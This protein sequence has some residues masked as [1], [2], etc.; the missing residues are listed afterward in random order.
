M[1]LLRHPVTFLALSL[2]GLLL[3]LVTAS[4]PLYLA[5]ASS[6]AVGN[7]I[8]RAGPAVAGLT[9]RSSGPLS[10][11][12]IRY[13]TA[14]LDTAV[15]RIDGLRPAVS[16]AAASEALSLENVVAAR[17]I[18]HPVAVAATRTD[19]VRNLTILSRAPGRGWWMARSI[20]A[21]AQVR[22][23]DQ[24]Q[25]SMLRDDGSPLPLG[26]V[27]VVGI[28]RDLSGLP[29]SSYWY[30]IHRFILPTRLGDPLPPPLLLADQQTFSRLVSN[31]AADGFV[32]WEYW[33]EQP[34]YPPEK[35][36]LM[37][38]GIRRFGAQLADPSSAIGIGFGSSYS[39]FPDI[40]AAGTKTAQV[41]SGPIRSLVVA[42]QVVVLLLLVAAGLYAV[43]RRRAEFA[44]LY[45]RGLGAPQLGLK[46]GLESLAPLVAGGLVGWWLALAAVHTFGPSTVTGRAA[47]RVAA[48][49]SAIS[50]GV[51]I[52]T[53]VTGVTVAVWAAEPR[54]PSK[55]KTMARRIPW[56]API[57]GVGL[58]ALYELLRRP[59]VSLD[60]L[61]AIPAVD[62]FLPLFP[63]LF[64][65]G[66]GG[67]A[68]RILGRLLLTI[69]RERSHGP[70]WMYLAARR[71]AAARRQGA[72]L[73]G[74]R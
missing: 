44:S 7:G 53:L 68:G 8:A 38:D 26:R 6:S 71:L 51:G 19:F 21:L 30:P 39:G 50:L 67:A 12:R 20:A 34:T 32:Q 64:L 47:L 24:V 73:R 25:V 29:E 55:V 40:A 57:F 15:H 66:A 35:A 49:A 59:P 28:Y 70:I 18:G 46:L 54:R 45:S 69:R 62:A 27:R 17:T 13:R 65:V 2:A 3:T 52:L 33:T 5:S 42:I 10:A 41:L 48:A 58:A 4:G 23:G 72:D 22:A 9:V 56:E 11:D 74:E 36:E 1:L 43:N 37:D 31:V 14:L 16:F 61:Q 63:I 60:S